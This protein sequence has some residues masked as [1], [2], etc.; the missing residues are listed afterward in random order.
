MAVNL[1]MSLRLTWCKLRDFT[2]P[3]TGVNHQSMAL[4]STAIYIMAW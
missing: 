3:D 4:H 1:A 2:H